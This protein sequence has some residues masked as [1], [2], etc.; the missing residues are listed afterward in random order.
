MDT[1]ELDRNAL[2]IYLRD[3]SALALIKNRIYKECGTQCYRSNA[4]R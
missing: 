2:V 1:H 4:Y 3:V